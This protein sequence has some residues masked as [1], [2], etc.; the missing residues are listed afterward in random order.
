[1]S[2]IQ[3]NQNIF[4]IDLEYIVE[5]EQVEPHLQAHLDFMDQCYDTGLFLASGAKVPRTGG[6]ILAASDSR[7]EIESLLAKDPFSIHKLARYT[8]TEF[9][10]RRKVEGL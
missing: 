6:I 10:P 3:E 2:L 5:L 1:M 4:I 9:H 8:V 7:D